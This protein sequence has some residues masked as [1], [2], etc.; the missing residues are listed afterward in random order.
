MPGFS[1]WIKVGL[2]LTV[3]VVVGAIVAG[4]V[5]RHRRN[6]R[7]MAIAAAHLESGSVRGSRKKKQEK[8]SGVE[9]GAILSTPRRIRQSGSG[10]ASGSSGRREG[11]SSSRGQRSR[12]ERRGG[13]G[14][15]S[16]Q[17]SGR[18]LRRQSDQ[19]PTDAAR[20]QAFTQGLD[21]EIQEL[22]SGRVVHDDS[23]RT[24]RDLAHVEVYSP[25]STLVPENEE[26][27]YPFQHLSRPQP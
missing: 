19:D 14:G 3:I 6:K 11:G 1:P 7:A 26:N 27:E 24:D 10:S 15:G 22:E 4:L 17:A 5:I 23:W 9:L 2:S 21:E 20:R 8:D 16:R 12:R 13:G 18:S 25:T